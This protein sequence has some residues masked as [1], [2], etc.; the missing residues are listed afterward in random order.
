[1][2][3]RQDQ[4]KRRRILTAAFEMFGEV[5]YRDTTI[6]DI[7]RKAEVAAGSIYTYFEDKETL[8]R[9]TVEEGWNRFIQDI[10]EATATLGSYEAKLNALIDIGFCHI[11]EAYPLLRGMF[12]E[13]NRLQLFRTNLDRLCSGILNVFEVDG[14]FSVGRSR[15]ERSFL[16]RII[17]SGLLFIVSVTPPE[18]LGEE[19]EKMKHGLRNGFIDQRQ[20][21]L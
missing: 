15:E 10:S 1:M 16:I 12:C 4:E 7:A 3:R 8:F 14:G 6:K 5:G 20:P 13:A 18:Q 2:A 19:I 17:V 21:A 11:K 9:S